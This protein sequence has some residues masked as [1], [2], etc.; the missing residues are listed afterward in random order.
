MSTLQDRNV[1]GRHWHAIAEYLSGIRPLTSRP[2]ASTPAQPGEITHIHP[3]NSSRTYP[4]PKKY[5]DFV[6]K[7]ETT[8]PLPRYAPQR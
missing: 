6:M 3:D 2:S 8:V 4:T 5:A 7:D 1:K